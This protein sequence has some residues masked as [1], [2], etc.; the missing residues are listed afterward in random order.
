MEL[1]E[2]SR[3]KSELKPDVPRKLYVSEDLVN[4]LFFCVSEMSLMS[5]FQAN[6]K[7][8]FIKK[9][10]IRDLYM[11]NSYENYRPNLVITNIN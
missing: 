7:S 1:L 11:K 4:E 2:M 9:D 10:F 6:S 8:F 5:S 3:R